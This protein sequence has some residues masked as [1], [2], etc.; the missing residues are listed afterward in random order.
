MSFSRII[1]LLLGCAAGASEQFQPLFEGE[2]LE[3]WIIDTPGLWSAR[4]GV[5]TGKSPG[6]KYN[7]FLRTKKQYKNFVLKVT[8]RMSDPTGKANSGIQF[9]SKAIHA[10]HEV[11][12][13]QADIGQQYWGCLYDES[14]R[15]KVLVQASPEALAKIRKDGWNEYVITANGNRITLQLNGAT[16]AEWLE[17]EAG[18][19]DSGFIALQLH[20]GPA[21]EMQF[22]DL[23]IRELPD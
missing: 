3:E 8:F 12:G 13:Y 1:V 18:I 14:R 21:F 5:I 6:L 7:D 2:N 20:S 23:L 9:R 17:Q 16:S 15:N 10:S 11:S 19:E 22:K 4:N